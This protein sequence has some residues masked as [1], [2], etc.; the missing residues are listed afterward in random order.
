LKCEL[1]IEDLHAKIDA[2]RQAQWEELLSL[3]RRQI[4]LLE[5]LAPTPHAPQA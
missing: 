2:L 1:E 4:E 5:Q 3:Q